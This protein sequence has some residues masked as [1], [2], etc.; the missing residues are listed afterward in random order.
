MARSTKRPPPEEPRSPA[1][2]TMSRQEADAKLAARLDKAS[3]VR[4]RFGAPGE[5]SVEQAFEGWDRYNAELLARM[6]TDSSVA[7][8]YRYCGPAPVISMSR[9]PSLAARRGDFLADFDGSASRE[10]KRLRDR[11][12]A[13]V[14]WLEQLRQRLEVYGE[15]E[16]PDPATAL[17]ARTAGAQRRAAF[18]VHGH[19]GAA[20]EATARM[21]QQLGV[22]AVVLHEQ[23]NR[24]QT[25]IEKFEHHSDVLFA[26]VLLTPDDVGRAK[27]ESDLQPRARQ[28]VWFELGFFVGKLGR[29]HVCAL[30]KGPLEIPS[31]IQGVIYT[32]MDDAGAWRFQLAKELHAAGIAV[33]L[34]RLLGS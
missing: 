28:N 30:H 25:V 18:V 17:P 4:S 33:D 19:D 34:N 7:D 23:A 8:S 12:D 14:V 11:F 1:A 20:R 32:R 5:P 6:F 10:E 16:S 31:D 26:V 15:P 3:E 2:L 24:G 29:D 27:T 9:S 22:E 13:K 21:L